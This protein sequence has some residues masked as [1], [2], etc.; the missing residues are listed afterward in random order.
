MGNQQHS[1]ALERRPYFSLGFNQI[2]PT[3]PAKK[4]RPSDLLKEKGI[5]FSF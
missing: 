2:F 1:E 5:P 4:K 3:K